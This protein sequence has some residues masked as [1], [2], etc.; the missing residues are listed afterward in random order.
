MLDQILE[1]LLQRAS[2]QEGQGRLQSVRMQYFLKAKSGVLYLKD[3]PAA[4]A[5][6]D[7]EV[8]ASKSISTRGRPRKAAVG[9]Y[10]LLS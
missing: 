6:S 8:P 10:A 1:C 3:P 5:G 7:S 4:H 2:L 9:T